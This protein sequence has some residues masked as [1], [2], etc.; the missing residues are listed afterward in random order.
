MGTMKNYLRF[1]SWFEK[2][3]FKE[4]NLFPPQFSNFMP[5]S[6][7][8]KTFKMKIPERKIEAKR[9]IKIQYLNLKSFKL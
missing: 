1:L 9:N 3:F 7:L 4:N 8:I 5:L 6:H 2:C